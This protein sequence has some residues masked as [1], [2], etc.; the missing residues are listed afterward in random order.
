MLA[1]EDDVKKGKGLARAWKHAE[2]LVQGERPGALN[3][4]LMERMRN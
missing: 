3:N 1:I 4:A 2:E